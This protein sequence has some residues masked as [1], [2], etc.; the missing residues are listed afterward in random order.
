MLLAKPIAEH[1][2]AELKLTA[3]LLA[4]AHAATGDGRYARAVEE[5]EDEM[6]RRRH[7]EPNP[8]ETKGDC[9]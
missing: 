4:S 9:R 2:D 8:Y 5:A 7:A 3:Q 6:V 1:T